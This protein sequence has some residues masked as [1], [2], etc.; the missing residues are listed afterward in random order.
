MM[1][2]SAAALSRPLNGRDPDD[3]VLVSERVFAIADGLDHGVGSGCQ[4]L[5]EL[6]RR[7]GP[8]PYPHPRLIRSA[9]R[10]AH[11]ALWFRDNHTF[12]LRSTAT[13]VVWFGTLVAIGHVGDCRAYL[14]SNGEAIQLTSDQSLSI[15]SDDGVTR[16]GHH[17]RPP[18]PEIRRL[19]ILSGDRLVLSTDGLWR[20]LSPSQLADHRLLTP[21]DAC[22]ALCAGVPLGEEE[23]SV[24]VVDFI[25]DAALPRQRTSSGSYG[26]LS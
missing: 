11:F 15:T 21:T 26:P 23:A 3:A 8:H 25:D 22:A 12:T 10:G 17:Q 7:L 14:I 13:V 16:L 20:Q 6:A 24:V 5:L 1:R 19:R 4:A 2:A 9:F 18:D